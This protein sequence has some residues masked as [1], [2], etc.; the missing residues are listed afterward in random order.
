MRVR[1]LR[2]RDYKLRW[3]MRGRLLL[4]KRSKRGNIIIECLKKMKE[5]MN[6]SGK[7]ERKYD[8]KT[9][10][11]KKHTQPCSTNKNKIAKMK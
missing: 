9:L 6:S 1:W 7:S 4:R 10:I 3:I 2:L 5:I 11:C 8:K